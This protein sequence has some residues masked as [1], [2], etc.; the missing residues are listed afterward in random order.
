M[1][2]E[3][4]LA[5]WNKYYDQANVLVVLKGEDWIELTVEDLRELLKEPKKHGYVVPPWGA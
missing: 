4:T 2:K 5:V 3:G 1:S